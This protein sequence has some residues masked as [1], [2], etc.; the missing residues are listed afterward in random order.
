MS[1]L[2]RAAQNFLNYIVAMK[3]RSAVVC[4]HR[5]TFSFLVVSLAA[6]SLGAQGLASVAVPKSGENPTAVYH[7]KVREA[8]TTVLQ[9]WTESLEKKD[10]AGSL[11]LT[12][13]TFARSSATAAKR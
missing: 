2:C 8:I 10:S 6:R 3:F 4:I 1:N 5:F 7:A 11:L 13:T 12:R 9:S